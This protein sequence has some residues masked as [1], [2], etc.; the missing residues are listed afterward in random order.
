MVDAAGQFA[1]EGPVRPA[2]PGWLPRMRRAI[3]FGLG[4]ADA[5]VVALAGFLLRGGFIVVLLPI[6]VLPSV[7]GVAGA[8]GVDA[9][10]IDGHPTAWL[11]EIA[12]IVA[13]VAAAYLILAFVVGS[14]VDVIVIGAAIDHES[15]TTPRTRTLPSSG[16]VLDLAV[17]RAICAAPLGPAIYWAGVQIWASAYDELTTPT[18]LASPL[19]ARVLQAVAPAVVVLAVAWL[20]SEVVGA[21]VIRRMILLDTGIIRSFA[22]GLFQ[23]IRRPISTTATALISYGVSAGA[24]GLAI[25][26]SATAFDWCRIAARASQSITITIGVAPFSTTRD[27]RPVV[28]ALTAAALCVSWLAA[29]VIAGVTSAWRSAALTG[30][31]LAAEPTV[32]IEAAAQR[33]GLLGQDSDRSGD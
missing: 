4:D 16:L 21:I 12:A 20:L 17:V 14:L 18:N 6:V 28:F 30:E 29:L 13:V 9:F 11:F 7:I 26:A 1:R 23:M 22:G 31:T 24:I 19:V 2:R 5:T 27:F 10:G 33:C 8:T 32:D 25:V 3:Q 15:G